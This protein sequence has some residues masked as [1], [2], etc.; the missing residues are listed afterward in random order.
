M[1]KTLSFWQS[2]LLALLAGAITV[3]SFAPFGIW[4][5]AIPALASLF[6]L[7]MSSERKAAAMHGFC[8]GLGLFGAGVS[9]VFNSIYEFGQA[10]MVFAVFLTVLFVLVLSLF[11]AAVGFFSKFW[12]SDNQRRYLFVVLP[13]LWV[14]AEW[15]RGWILTGFPWL[16][17][18]YGQISS[19]LAAIAPFLG[20]LGVSWIVALCAASLTYLVLVGRDAV[21]ESVIGLVLIF[22]LSL[23]LGLIDVT[24]VD[25]DPRKITL[26]QGN[27]AQENKWEADWLGPTI[28]R[29]VEQTRANWTSDIVI[30]PEVALPGYYR[31]FEATVLKP[32]M[33]EAE[34]N[35]TSIVSGML[36]TDGE[37]AWN[38]VV[39]F[40]QEPEIYRKRHL[41]PFG[42]Y[43]PMRGFFE[44]FGELVVLPAGT[45][46]PGKEAKIIDVDGTRFAT[47]ICYEDAYGNEMAD[48]LPN[49]NLLL[50]VSNDAWFGDSLAP[51]QHLQI[52]QMRSL[53]LGR[54]MVRANN[55]GVT[56]F[57]SHRGELFDTAPQ[58]EVTSITAS[59]QPR[60]GTT[61]YVLW[62]NWGVIIFM[63]LLLVAVRS[64]QKKLITKS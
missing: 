29:Y 25:G 4:P 40:G 22:A 54:E 18:G 51:H 24:K 59:V 3:L 41:V 10:P 33:A 50:N 30:W 53:E 61:P 6:F 48:M 16:Q 12:R 55:T 44:L 63:T 52:A 27:I 17:L 2:N 28:D 36:T 1:K 23:V 14:L 45:M 20:V 8:F 46:R 62:K 37:V 5:L 7:F 64:L 32:L 42:E 31:Q 21:K 35:N 56:A 34:A 11:P 57:I 39:K 58:F 38:S 13:A 19:P 47:S 43:L 9:W 60:A 15:L 49:A 26:I